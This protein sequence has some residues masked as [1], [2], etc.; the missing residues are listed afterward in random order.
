MTCLNVDIPGRAYEIVVE[1][2]LIESLGERVRA[3]APHDRALVVVDASIANSHGSR[4]IESLGSAGYDLAVAEVVSDE[5]TKSLESA[6][7]LYDQMLASRLERGSPV[8]AIGGGVVGDLAGFSAATYL[9]GVP[10]IHVPTTVVAMV[11]AAIGGKTGVN[12]ALPNGDLGKNLI[13]AFWQPRGVL[14]DPAV[15]D[16]LPP[17]ELRC[18]LA[19]CVKHALIADAALL[20]FIQTEMRSLLALNAAKID[21]L[22]VRSASIKAGIVS[23]DERESGERA[24]LN[25]GHTFAHAIEPLGT[26]G[27]KHGEAVS[28]GLVAA[29][30]CA[31][32]LGRVTDE[33]I[34][35]VT[36]VLEN[37]GLPTQ[38]PRPV[39]VD[40]LVAM[41]Q[42][43]KKVQRGRVRLVLPQGIGAAAV[44]S[45]VPE[46]VVRTTWAS[47][48]AA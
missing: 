35:L 25:L 43:D 32:M 3:L 26:L 40:R 21:R 29:M 45:D 44:V 18:G 38:L 11:D 4:A 13:G 2:G 36:H 1:R 23:R 19:E 28:I 30:R 37:L 34:D 24:L 31:G 9:R 42:F 15:L 39:A 16:T 8:I 7:R 17:R 47:I 12:V 14:V 48:G 20:E 46:T 6:R 33:E 27:L 41:M 10:L 5:S 22:L